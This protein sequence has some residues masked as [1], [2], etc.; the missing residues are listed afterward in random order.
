LPETIKANAKSRAR[1][2]SEGSRLSKG[3]GK[4]QAS[5]ELKCETCGKG[6]KHSSCLYKHLSVSLR[7]IHSPIYYPP[8]YP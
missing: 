2:A 3:E 6:Y 7:L 5:G 4:R 8:L 1:R